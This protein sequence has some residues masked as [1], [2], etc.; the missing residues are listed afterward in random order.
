[1]KGESQGKV[2]A[3]D[4]IHFWHWHTVTVGWERSGQDAPY[5]SNPHQCNTLL[6]LQSSSQHTGIQME[7]L[8]LESELLARC[9]PRKEFPCATNCCKIGPKAP[10]YKISQLLYRSNLSTQHYK[11]GVT[12]NT[13]WKGCWILSL[14]AMNQNFAPGEEG[15]RFPADGAGEGGHYCCNDLALPLLP[16]E[17]LPLG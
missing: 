10:C 13:L 3:S 2:R 5:R 4:Q 12:R 8:N 15:G 11:R 14:W 9:F 1:M 17:Q 6:G 7:S 16:P